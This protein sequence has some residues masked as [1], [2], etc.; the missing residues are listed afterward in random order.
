[1]PLLPPG[2]G[3]CQSGQCWLPQDES[4]RANHIKGVY[5]YGELS[6]PTSRE[7]G[8]STAS[9]KCLYT[10]AQSMENKQELEISVQAQSHD[11]TAITETWQDSS[12][13]ECYNGFLCT[14]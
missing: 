10:N 7:P 9:L 12:P 11:L 4:P 3:L 6:Y 1:M 2:S 8:C 14:F 5:G 13:L